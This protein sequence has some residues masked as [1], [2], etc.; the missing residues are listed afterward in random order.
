M[1]RLSTLVTNIVRNTGTWGGTVADGERSRSSS[2]W[3]QDLIRKKN[4]TDAAARKNLNKLES[5]STLRAVKGRHVLPPL[6]M[7]SDHIVLIQGT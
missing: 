6:H 5:D 3:G 1:K 2:N 7:L 4:A